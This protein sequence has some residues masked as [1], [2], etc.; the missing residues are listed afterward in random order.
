MFECGFDC[1]KMSML[2]VVGLLH[3]GSASPCES[4][5]PCRANGIFRE[6]LRQRIRELTIMCRNISVTSHD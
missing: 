1:Q 2:A 3:D 4:A 5:T 6:N